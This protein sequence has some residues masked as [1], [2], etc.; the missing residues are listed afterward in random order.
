MEISSRE[1]WIKAKTDVIEQKVEQT[2]CNSLS[3]VQ[4][5][6][7]CYMSAV[8]EVAFRSMEH[9]F[10]PKIFDW[11]KKSHFSHRDVNDEKNK[12]YLV[13]HEVK[14]YYVKYKKLLITAYG[15][16]NV[17]DI[18]SDK[19][20]DTAIKTT[21][22]TTGQTK[23]LKGE[24]HGTIFEGGHQ[25]NFMMALLSASNRTF[26]P[27]I[28]GNVDDIYDKFLDQKTTLKD[29]ILIEAPLRENIKLKSIVE[30]YLIPIAK[31]I[32][33]SLNYKVAGY[34]IGIEQL[35]NKIHSYHAISGFLC[36]EDFLICN[37]WKGDNTCTSYHTS[38]IDK[39]SSKDIDVV[40]FLCIICKKTPEEIEIA[41]KTINAINDPQWNNADISNKEEIVLLQAQ[42]NNR[43]PVLEAEKKQLNTTL[44]VSYKQL[45][46]LPTD[47]NLSNNKLSVLPDSF[48]NLTNLTDLN[49]DF[50]KLNKL[51]DNFGNLTNLT[52][53]NLSSNQLSVLP[54][55]FGNLTNLTDLNLDF[56]KLNKLPDNFGNLTN[57]TTLNLKFSTFDALPDSF[58]NL[59]NLTT[60]ILSNNKLT[61]VPNNFGNLTNLTNL[62]LQF[63]TFD[64]LPD[65]FGNLTNL[66]TLVLSNKL[67]TVPDSF[68]KLTNLTALNLSNNKLTTLPDSFSKLTSLTELNLSHN[69][70]TTLPDSFISNLTSLTS[71]TDLNLI[72]NDTSF[73][74][75]TYIKL[76]TNLPKLTMLNYINIPPTSRQKPED[77][78]KVATDVAVAGGATPPLQ[79]GGSDPTDQIVPAPAINQSAIYQFL[80]EPA[81]NDTEE[82]EK[83]Q[84]FLNEK[85]IYKLTQELIDQYHL[86]S[87]PTGMRPS[88]HVLGQAAPGLPQQSELAIENPNPGNNYNL[89]MHFPEGASGD[90]RPPGVITRLTP[91]PGLNAFQWL[92]ELFRPTIPVKLVTGVGIPGSSPTVAAAEAMVTNAE[93]KVAAAEEEVANAEA[94]VA[95]LTSA[96]TSAKT[97]TLRQ[98]G[99]E[100]QA[101]LA[102]AKSKLAAAKSELAAAEDELAA[103]KAAA[104]AAAKAAP[105]PVVVAAP[106]VVAPV[107]DQKQLNTALDAAK[108]QEL[109][110]LNTLESADIPTLDA[111]VASFTPI[112]DKLKTLIDS[113]A[114]LSDDIKNQVQ[115]AYST[116]I[117]LD[118]VKLIRLGIQKRLEDRAAD[119]KKL[120]E[121]AKVLAAYAAKKLAQRAA[122]SAAVTA[123][124]VGGPVGLAM[125]ALTATSA[126]GT[127]WK[128]AKAAKHLNEL[129]SSYHN[130]KEE[131]DRGK[132]AIRAIVVAL[133]KKLEV[134][135]PP[136]PPTPTPEPPTPE[137]PTPEP[138]PTPTPTPPPPTP[139]TPPPPTTPTP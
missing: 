89:S 57:L 79:A 11:I 42:I 48:G 71:L 120:E 78:K 58:G 115:I 45:K 75:N 77:I 1:R 12:C 37:Q 59:T 117:A 73:D 53:L 19:S 22:Q 80:N 100:T 23:A 97:P 84:E 24:D 105:V 103:A 124:G 27:I 34:T 3:T 31:T 81:D 20:P 52:T 125:G 83:R 54:D 128:A 90:P 122:A 96:L 93:A 82:K 10:T 44:D 66:T 7:T 134:P 40:G 43:L 118:N 91:G 74:V 113:G 13:P 98:V 14:E 130:L 9:I 55:S 32:N 41:K 47:L 39:L 64:A 131:E 4:Y 106:V 108:T 62:N 26:T 36:K 60:L 110:I 17:D 25:I 111:K 67:T 126:L 18:Y 138:T 29:V 129:R 127:G 49:L 38:T 135:P 16:I 99:G 87:E 85:G 61:T 109:E 137:P 2:T 21:G 95:K 56:N 92:R 104:E 72:N 46:Q 28:I 6:G 132:I 8:T 133:A 136:E 33:V 76:I 88:G 102:A 107:V 68:S 86:Q 94:R 139:P 69:K 123:T 112:R 114:N 5:G 15:L 119:I 63:S 65:S 121:D 30:D 70:L 51:P 116:V 101:E 50:N 35:D